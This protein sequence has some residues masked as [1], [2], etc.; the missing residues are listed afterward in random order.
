MEP[1]FWIAVGGGSIA[2]GGIIVTAMIRMPWGKKSTNNPGVSEDDCT[3]RRK[4]N[5]KLFNSKI[6]TVDTKLDG[7]KDMQVEQSQTLKT[8][9][10]TTTEIL[11][12]VKIK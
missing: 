12:A 2:I 5:E 1:E 7:V 4:S 3:D 10:D 6:E 11:K 9:G 8:I